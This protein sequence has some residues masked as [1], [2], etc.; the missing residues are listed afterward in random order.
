MGGES[1]IRGCSFEGYK[2]KHLFSYIQSS[3]TSILF[4]RCVFDTF[5]G[6]AK[7]LGETSRNYNKIDF[8]NCRFKNTQFLKNSR[9][10]S[11]TLRSY[12]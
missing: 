3:K 1:V 12:R 8:E 9:F 10:N 7:K 2:D 6:M 11:S 4:D 5:K